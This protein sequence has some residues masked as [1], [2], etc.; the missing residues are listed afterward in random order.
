MQRKLLRSN[1]RMAA[2]I[3][4]GVTSSVHV[5]G[6]TYMGRHIITTNQWRL[7]VSLE[8][9]SEQLRKVKMRSFQFTRC[10]GGCK[11]LDCGLIVMSPFGMELRSKRFEGIKCPSLRLFTSLMNIF[12]REVSLWISWQTWVFQVFLYLCVTLFFTR[13]F[14]GHE[15]FILSLCKVYSVFGIRTKITFYGRFPLVI[16]LEWSWLLHTYSKMIN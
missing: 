2:T 1:W 12:I 16:S 4:W 6:I 13:T 15:L 7:C 11:K 5:K 8:G 14:V 10:L 3:H 9:K